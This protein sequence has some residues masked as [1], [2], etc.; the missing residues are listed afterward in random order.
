LAGATTIPR[1]EATI[2]TGQA[3]IVGDGRRQN[4]VCGE[5]MTRRDSLA[6]THGRRAGAVL[7]TGVAAIR[8]EIASLA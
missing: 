3:Y 1:D 4:R 7:S 2:G 5:A 6:M 8:L